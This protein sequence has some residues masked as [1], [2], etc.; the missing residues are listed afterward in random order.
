MKNHNHELTPKQQAEI[1]ALMA[2]SEDE[3][4]T[5]D[6]PEATDWS[7]AIR[8]MFH[9]TPDE[10]NEAIRRLRSRRDKPTYRIEREQV[11]APT[12]TD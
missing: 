2:M 11:F 12:D 1:D 4:D 3:I 7:G 5:S 9:M 8:G 6:I 10:R